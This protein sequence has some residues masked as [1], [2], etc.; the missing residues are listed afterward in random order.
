MSKTENIVLVI[1][2]VL[3]VGGLIFSLSSFFTK[4]NQ[5]S[6]I[7]T[8]SVKVDTNQPTTTSSKFPTRVSDSEVTIDLTP[9]E[10]KDGKLYVSIGVNTHTT[11]LSPFDLKQLT[12]LEYDSLAI[13][14]TSVPQLSGHHNSGTLIFD[15]GK[16]LTQFRIKIKGIPTIQERIFE[17]GY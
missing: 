17:W 3:V 11:D 15:V 9:Q 14:P 1:L 4:S 10:F 6:I 12:T 2:V 13:K 5:N 8:S 7:K 16:E